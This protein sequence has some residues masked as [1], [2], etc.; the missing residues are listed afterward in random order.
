MAMLLIFIIDTPRYYRSAVNRHNRY[1][2]LMPLQN[3][4]KSRPL[5][6]KYIYLG[7]VQYAYTVYDPKVK[8]W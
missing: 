6:L 3:M 1:P 5:S 2:T 8:V 7:F 4:D